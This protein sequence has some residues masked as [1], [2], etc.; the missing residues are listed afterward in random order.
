MADVMP[1]VVDEPDDRRI[2]R[3]RLAIHLAETFAALLG[4]P[5]L[6]L[7]VVLYAMYR[8]YEMSPEPMRLQL[9]P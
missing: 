1:Y 4:P 2:E 6:M 3:R 9:A 8:A 7:G 5:L